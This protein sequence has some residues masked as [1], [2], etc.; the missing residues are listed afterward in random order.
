MNRC[1]DIFSQETKTVTNKNY[2]EFA[3]GPALQKFIPNPYW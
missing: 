2:H 3:I 1:D